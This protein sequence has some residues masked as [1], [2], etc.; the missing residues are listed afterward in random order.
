MPSSPADLIVATGN[1]GKLAEIGAVLAGLPCSLIPVTDLVAGFDPPEVGETYRENAAIKAVAA[2]MAT[3]RPAIAD[4]SGL[5]VAALG[6]TPGVR[7]ARYAGTGRDADNI[8]K[9]LA[10]IEEI[11]EEKRGARFVCVIALAL[12]GG[13]IRFFRGE[14]RG[15][16]TKAPRGEKGFGYDPIFLVPRLGRTMAELA[17]EEKNVI[18]HRARALA[19]LRAHLEGSPL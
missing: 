1:R 5:E 13:S 18:S 16:I 17:P 19:R 7:S 6:N 9:L 8:A 14:C 15:V 10:S 12:P 3:G 4:D 11:P 2:C